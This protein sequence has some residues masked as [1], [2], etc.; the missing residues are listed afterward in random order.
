MKVLKTV[1]AGVFVVLMVVSLGIW[2]FGQDNLKID[3]NKL[4]NLIDSPRTKQILAAKIDGY[5]GISFDMNTLAIDF[6]RDSVL[7]ATVD[8]E[9]VPSGKQG[10]ASFAYKWLDGEFI[11]IHVSY[12]FWGTAVS[13]NISS[14]TTWNA[15]GSPYYVTN[16]I[17]VNSGVT[18]TIEPGTVVRFRKFTQGGI[19]MDVA[20]TLIC[21]G[22]TF[23]TSC[24]FEDYDQS[25]IYYSDWYGI[26]VY[27]AGNCTVTDSLF[28]FASNG[29]SAS[30][31]TGD[32]TISGCT[33]RKCYNGVGLYQVSGT[34]LIEDNIITEC[35]EGIYCYY[36]TASTQITG[37][38]ITG[39]YY[40]WTGIYCYESSPTISSNSISDFS[41]GLYCYSNSSPE[42][43]LN[44]IEDNYYYGVY[45]YSNSQPI[46]SNNN[47][48]GNYSYG[49]YNGDSMVVIDAEN[50]WWGD[51]SGPY[52]ATLNPGGL[53]NDVSD[54]VDF[55]PWLTSMV[56]AMVAALI[57]R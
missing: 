15:A 20:G 27:S 24:D 23:T 41:Y 18:L 52:H 4:A 57:G 9:H 38:T 55:D 46:I 29:L 8:F 50:N 16:W 2:S 12:W 13:G 25:Q 30:S 21:D 39:G 6:F 45:C 48:Q 22:A 49:I 56:T 53:G 19:E 51:A 37:N 35:D 44:T 34:C 17:N 54:Y 47:I 3:E 14:D 7:V 28:E 5:P 42:V 26:Y 1:F 36:Q 10:T 11:L 40:G 33:M 31:A 32:I 43:T